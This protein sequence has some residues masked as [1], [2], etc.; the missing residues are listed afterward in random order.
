[1]SSL[2]G[3]TFQTNKKNQIH[4]LGLREIEELSCIE[5]KFDQ[6]EN[7]ACHNYLQLMILKFKK[8]LPFYFVLIFSLE[9]FARTKSWNWAI[10]LEDYNSSGNKIGRLNVLQNIQFKMI[11]YFVC[12]LL[13]V[14][15]FQAQVQKWDINK[16]DNL[17]GE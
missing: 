8:R 16:I 12:L 13:T 3:Q 5:L 4:N 17:I 6:F 11:I 10:W 2:G 7:V 15:S 14:V 9:N 1:M